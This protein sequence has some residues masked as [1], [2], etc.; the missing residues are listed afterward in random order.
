MEP[1]PLINPAAVA[2]P[3]RVPKST[4]AVP[5]TSESGGN[6]SS[7]RKKRQPPNIQLVCGNLSKKYS[8]RAEPS[9]QTT[10]IGLRLE[11]QSRSEITPASNT[12]SGPANSNNAPSQPDF[13]IPVPNCSWRYFG[14]H[15]KI[16]Y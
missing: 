6:N 16:A 8:N 15:N 4:A 7:P 10:Q 9:R 11:P 13:A 5:L 2:A 12:L 14:D 1:Q 3:S